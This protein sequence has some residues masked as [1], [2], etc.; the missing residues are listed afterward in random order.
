MVK[1]R[2]SA[3]EAFWYDEKM[4]YRPGIGT[5]VFIL[6]VTMGGGGIYVW[7]NMMKS[8]KSPSA[9]PSVSQSDKPETKPATSTQKL[10]IGDPN[11][12]LTVVEYG[13]FQCPI[14]KNFFK[15]T[16]QTL[17]KEFIDTGKA[18]IEFRVETHL[19]AESVTAGEAAYCANDQAQFTSYH[20]A[21][22]Q[23]QQ[24]VNSG[25]FSAANLKQIAAD[26]GLDAEKF[27]ACL[28]KGTYRAKVTASND[29]AHKQ[30]VTATPTFFVGNN[31]ITGVQP[32]Q[33]FRTLLQ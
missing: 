27:A 8:A 9:Q 23:H 15:T 28:D 18:N 7:N 16:E 14:C 17:R 33:T 31:K 25:A 19:G 32:I 6:L 4:K 29:D 2:R 12:P 13:D 5:L 21:L 3:V 24:G 11:A 26:V 1:E 30:G 10:I 22:Y 20:D